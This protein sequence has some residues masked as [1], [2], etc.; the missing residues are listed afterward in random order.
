MRFSDLTIQERVGAGGFGLVY[1]ASCRLRDGTTAEVALKQ[2]SRACSK[3]DLARFIREITTME[4][5]SHPNIVRIVGSVWQPS[6]MLV[7]E[8][9]AG[10][11]LHVLLAQGGI[12]SLLKQKM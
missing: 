10:G 2:P 4:A 5:L 6:I 11:S 9:M 12:G 8:W 1:R 3:R 7:L